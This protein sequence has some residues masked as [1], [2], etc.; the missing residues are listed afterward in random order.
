M[1]EKVPAAHVAR[2]FESPQEK[3]HSEGHRPFPADKKEANE[4]CKVVVDFILAKSPEAPVVELEEGELEDGELEEEAEG[5]GDEGGGGMFDFDDLEDLDEVDAAA[6]EIRQERR[7]QRR[8]CCSVREVW[9]R[10]ARM[11]ARRSEYIKAIEAKALACVGAAGDA[12]VAS[13]LL[14]ASTC[15]VPGMTAA[16]SAPL[17]KRQ[18]TAA[19]QQ[20]DFFLA[21]DFYSREMACYAE[22]DTERLAVAYSNR[23]AC[24]AKVRHFEAA[25]HDAK[26]AA[27]LRPDWG[28][29]WSR[30][31]AAAASLGE[32]GLQATREAW[33]KAVECDPNSQ[34]MESLFNAYS[35]SGDKRTE[36]GHYRKEQGNQAMRVGEWGT[37]IA[38][39]TV[40]I[41]MMPPPPKKE[42][43]EDDDA[44]LRSILY[45]NRC[46]CLC[47]LKLWHDAV[48][49]GQKATDFK[50]DYVKAHYRLGVA[51]LGCK[52]NE[53]AYVSFAKALDHDTT[54]RTARKGREVCLALVP[55]WESPRAM[56]RRARFSK[57][58]FR[59]TETTKIYALSDVHY[60]H[61]TNEEWCQNIHA[62]KFLD[63]VLIVSGN[64]AD[65]YRALNRALTTLRAK[66][67]RVFYVP[68]NHE[69]WIN[70]AE[71]K[72]FP[73][74][75]C[76]LWA[77]MELCDDLDVDIFP[78][79]VCKDTFIVPLLSWYCASFDIRD[80]FPD[81]KSQADKYAKWPIDPQQQVW[82]YMLRLNQEHLMKPYH[83]NVIT[84]SHFL[85]RTNLPVWR[86]HGVLKVSG[87]V[88]LDDL[89]HEARAT[90]HVYGHT[91]YRHHQVHDGVVYVHRPLGEAVDADGHL[92][93]IMCIFNGKNLCSE[94]V[95]IQ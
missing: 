3:V 76:K 36:H 61:A 66:F 27:E 53:Q 60:D 57:D 72:R 80:P 10:D 5:A 59:P 18:A 29:A 15:C 41:A 6:D 73:D 22:D 74:S 68:G 83:G 14:P 77:I 46:A 88:E 64:V 2:L 38:H 51:Y 47:R 55:Y 69:M 19:Y 11:Q 89:V 85:P 34:H 31:G 71:S 12:A 7:E 9:R 4:V 56:W 75:L 32:S 20:G 43:V 24:M 91:H 39:Y 21:Q 84:V 8:R 67:R 30:V 16:Q 58:C 79:A 40:G 86:E 70:S 45:A 17:W 78:A 23:S 44:L 82:R 92:D 65:S 37:G 13:G 81:P 95:Q 63:D 93:P 25:L 90:C 52:N 54:C 26:R 50:E 87:C 42:N 33:F 28:R 94:L 49:D 1:G 48:Q 62:T 35:N